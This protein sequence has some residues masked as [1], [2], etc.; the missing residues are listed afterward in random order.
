MIDLGISKIA[1]IA[2]VG[3]IV[4][5]PERLPKVARVAGTL[6]GRAQRY[7]AAVKNEVADQMNAAEIQELKKMAVAAADQIKSAE[8]VARESWSEQSRIDQER[9]AQMA[10]DA[11]HEQAMYSA[12]VS[13]ERT[14]DASAY[15]N[16]L[17]IAR[18]RR[19]GRASWA[20][21]R[22]RTPMWY[23]AQ[24]RLPKR[25]LSEAARMKKHRPHQSQTR[26]VKSSFF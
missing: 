4:L 7:L 8:Q 3:L 13:L 19:T 25:V 15:Q 10:H 6:F 18:A 11:D 16:A 14:V 26:T 22:Q 24:Q 12:P 17:A 21:K 5:G 9:F 20:L 2:V 1:I 23:K